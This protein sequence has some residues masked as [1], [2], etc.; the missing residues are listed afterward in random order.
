MRLELQALCVRLP[1]PLR[2]VRERSGFLLRL[3]DAALGEATPAP[4]LGTESV[5]QC[6]A[7]LRAFAARCE[8]LPLPGSLEELSALVAAQVGL[9][10]APAARHGVELA[11]LD[12]LA[13][14]RRV[15]LAQLL[16]ERPRA[17]VELS[18]VLFSAEP[19]ALA[20]EAE[21]LCA[22]GYRT[23]K[24]KVGA[25]ALHV[26]ALRLLRV[27]QRVGDRIAL[28]IDANGAWS[29]AGARVAL[30][31]LAP[32]RLALCEQ[33]VRAEEVASLRRLRVARICP[34][35]ADESVVPPAAREEVLTEGAPAAD[36][37]VLKPMVLG[38]V[39][40]ALA[41]AHRAH[42]L[43]VGSYVTSSIDGPV[44]R[45]AAAQLA[46]ALPSGDWPSGVCL[47]D[48]ADPYPVAGGRLLLP[49]GAGLGLAGEDVAP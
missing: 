15:T 14:A 2:S 49:S 10:A 38:G 7:A 3:G 39:L 42:R 28:R 45:A 40:P 44:A 34:L 21:G 47:R 31:G 12:A 6:Q 16:C 18:G 20:Q 22:A 32:L 27:R 35:A 19:D 30:R 8:A 17:A 26:E 37:V 13:R 11:L 24:I 43:G 9:A 36:V 5:A 25:Q 29:E 33:P 23:L 1:L 46:C 41:L 48:G 4:E